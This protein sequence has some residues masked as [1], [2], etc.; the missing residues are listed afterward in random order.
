MFIKSSRTKGYIWIVCLSSDEKLR[1]IEYLIVPLPNVD[2]LLP[3]CIDVKQLIFL[4]VKNRN[5]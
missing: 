1:R 2:Y 5:T 4:F 3:L